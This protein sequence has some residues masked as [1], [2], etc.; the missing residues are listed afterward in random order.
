MK[1]T[2][3]VR[4][5]TS[6]PHAAEFS[7]EVLREFGAAFPIGRPEGEERKTLI[8]CLFPTDVN[9]AGGPFTTYRL[10]LELAR[11]KQRRPTPDDVFEM[12]VRPDQ[13]LVDSAFDTCANG[14]LWYLVRD[15]IAAC[16]ETVLQSVVDALS[17][18][19]G[20]SQIADSLLQT[21]LTQDSEL[22]K[23]LRDLGILPPGKSP[24]DKPL[25]LLADSVQK[26][27]TPKSGHPPRWK[28][29][30]QETVVI[31]TALNAGP[32]CTVVLPVAWLLVRERVGDLSYVPQEVQD[33]LSYQGFW[34]M[35]ASEVILP[36][37]E[38]MLRRNVSI[39]NAAHELTVKTVSHHLNVAR[40]RP[41]SDPRR[42]VSVI[43]ADGNRW[44][45]HNNFRAGRTASRL[46]QAS[47]WLI[48][49]G[50]IDDNG[51]T[52]A[53]SEIL[54]V[55]GSTHAVGVGAS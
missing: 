30:L 45:Q 2:A 12:A 46:P 26:S 6:D 23:P 21:L 11:A 48:Q 42:D 37:L 39:R 25:R 8:S 29:K 50:L 24:L 4:T 47:G 31:R 22:E 32:G 49:L 7:R 41:D 55:A 54:N 18:G 16:H 36:S 1:N 34:R 51:C 17:V 52:S 27:T 33:L 20:Q 3:L 28:G 43:T 19:E 38:D 13:M 9:T 14:W 5:L 53:G 10:L 44:S 15:M 35:G 40:G